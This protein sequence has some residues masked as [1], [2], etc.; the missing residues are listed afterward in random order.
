MIRDSQFPIAG[1]P[2]CTFVSFVVQA[3]DL[4]TKDTKLHK[5]NQS[6]VDWQLEM[7]A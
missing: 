2:L 1:F 6:A 7:F 5:G 3:L 4:T